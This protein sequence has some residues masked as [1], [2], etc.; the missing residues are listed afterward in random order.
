MQPATS[1]RHAT[2]PCKA[3]V[4]NRDFIRESMQYPTI[5]FEAVQKYRCA[6]CLAIP[7]QLS[8]IPR[9]PIAVRTFPLSQSVAEPAVNEDLRKS[10]LVIEH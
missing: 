1:P 5:R 7:T 6:E 9:R 8:F 2:A 4:A 3:V 10:S